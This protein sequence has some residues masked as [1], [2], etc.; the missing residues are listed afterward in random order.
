V[1]SLSLSQAEQ[2]GV[3]KVVLQLKILNFK[4]QQ[5]KDKSNKKDLVKLLAKR[6]Q[7]SLVQMIFKLP[8]LKSILQE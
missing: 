4:F 8:I 2:N 5:I 7:N 1:F 3:F 6:Q